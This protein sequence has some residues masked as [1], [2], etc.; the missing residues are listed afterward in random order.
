MMIH[1]KYGNIINTHIKKMN[2]FND[3]D[4][5]IKLL[6]NDDR[7][8]PRPRLLLQHSRMNLFHLINDVKNRNVFQTTYKKEKHQ[9]PKN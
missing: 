1:E 6:T 4:K 9:D 2:K 3:F 7:N 8:I 5:V